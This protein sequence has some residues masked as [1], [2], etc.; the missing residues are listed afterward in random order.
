MSKNFCVIM[1]GGVGS[2]FWPMS[3]TKLP[4]Q[5]LDFFG[6][7]RSLLQMTFDR[8]NSIIPTENIFIVTNQLYLDL[9]KEQL[10]LLKENQI[11][12]EPQRR[13]TAP[14]IAWAS[15]HIKSLEPEANIVVSPADHLILNNAEF[16]DSIRKGL[17]F[18]SRNN[19]LLTLGIKPNHP[20]TG[21]GYI[22]ID[23]E[24]KEGFMKVKTF[25][26]KPNLELAKVFVESGEFL[27]NSGIFIWNVNSILNAFK[28]FQ[29]EIH[30]RFEN[31][32]SY[33]N[34]SSEMT[35]INENFPACPNISIDF[36]VMEKASNVFVHGVAFGWSDLGTWGALYDLSEKDADNNVSLKCK[37]LAYESHN[38]IISTPSNHLVVIQG[39][40]N[41]VIAEDNNVLLICKKEEEQRIRNFATDVKVNYGDEFI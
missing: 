38:N 31:G 1:G 16:S 7:G 19:V 10:P 25:T 34:T 39:L 4:K 11:L 29:P 17:D 14:C 23:D 32:K 15:Y 37:T 6:T 36:G 22:Q 2:R 41:Y 13:N 33:Y 24:Q 35:F 18:V 12:L 20:E 8:F 40:E 26:E 21:Y 28:E 27:W 3:R 5:F 30:T 9:V